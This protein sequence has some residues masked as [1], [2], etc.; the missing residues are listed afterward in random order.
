MTEQEVK[1]RLGFL[2]V[3]AVIS[4]LLVAIIGLVA[5]RPSGAADNCQRYADEA[6]AE[7]KRMSTFAEWHQ[8]AGVKALAWA[9]LYQGC[10]GGR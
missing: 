9:T 6:V 1:E 7:L 2:L 3:V 4:V 10:R 5:T 8:A